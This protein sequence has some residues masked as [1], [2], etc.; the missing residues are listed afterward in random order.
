MIAQPLQGLLSLLRSAVLQKSLKEFATANCDFFDLRTNSQ[1][2][3]GKKEEKL[4][5]NKELQ[6]KI[7]DEITLRI[8]LLTEQIKEFEQGE[9]KNSLEN[10]LERQYITKSYLKLKFKEDNETIHSTDRSN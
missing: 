7:L 3:Q 4:K 6:K 2:N 5:L 10:A 9:I 8:N 1:N